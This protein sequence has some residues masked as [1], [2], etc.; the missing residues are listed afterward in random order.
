MS[1]KYNYVTKEV[2]LKAIADG[3]K[4][5]W[6][7]LPDNFKG[8]SD[9]AIAAINAEG[10][11]VI[12]KFNK[13]II[14]NKEFILEH[15]H[16]EFYDYLTNELQNDYDVIVK[17]LEDA[18]KEYYRLYEIDSRMPFGYVPG[19]EKAYGEYMKLVGVLESKIEY[20][21]PYRQLAR[22]LLIRP[23]GK[24][25]SD[26]GLRIAANESIESLDNRVHI[27]SPIKSAIQSLSK[28][29]DLNEEEKALFEDAMI[30]G[31]ANAPI[32]KMVSE[33]LKSINNNEVILQCASDM[34]I[35]W[36]KENFNEETFEEKAIKGELRKCVPFEILGWDEVDNNL[37]F[38]NSIF[39][40]IGMTFNNNSLKEAYHKRL[41]DFLEKIATDRSI[42][43]EELVRSGKIFYPELSDGLEEKIIPIASRV[44]NQ[45]IRHWKSADK[46]S[47][48]I[49]N[50]I[51]KSLNNL[52]EDDQLTA[53]QLLNQDSEI[54]EEFENSSDKTR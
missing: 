19:L 31:P 13:G 28:T 47:L 32:M 21:S 11:K 7:E 53:E 46:E 35:N 33:K 38:L 20:M 49:Y 8:D 30:N 36:V 5:D 14:S 6:D 3:K 1:V 41:N 24:K 9:I 54:D 18:G 43:L 17:I 2:M 22:K 39:N 42:D 15:P 45:V 23:Y 27:L 50:H 52:K 25:W 16:K 29:L 37:Q 48:L 4:I 10:M 44:A 51:L 40:S 34:H 26:V 12:K